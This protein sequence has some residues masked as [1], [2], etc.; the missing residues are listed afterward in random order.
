MVAFS[1]SSFDKT[2]VQPHTLLC[3]FLYLCQLFVWNSMKLLNVWGCTDQS[4]GCLSLLLITSDAG[5]RAGGRLVVNSDYEK[6][7]YCIHA[8]NCEGVIPFNTPHPHTNGWDFLVGWLCQHLW[9]L[10]TFWEVWEKMGYFW[11]L[12]WYFWSFLLRGIVNL[13]HP[14]EV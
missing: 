8:G 11:G 2:S 13:P 1:N 9:S 12:W 3:M 7:Q 4:D 6:R 10:E 14:K 5:R